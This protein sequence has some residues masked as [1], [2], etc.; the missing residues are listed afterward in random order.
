MT[1]PPGLDELRAATTRSGI[2]SLLG[3]PWSTL[4][5]MLFRQGPGSY[6]RSWT[7]KKKSGGVRKITAPTPHLYR[8]QKNLHA[9]LTSAHSARPANHGF[10]QNRSIIT[11]ASHHTG[12]RFVLTVDLKD[13]FPSIHFGRVRGLFL[14]PPFECSA[15]AATLLAQIACVDDVLPT[16]APTSPI[17][18][19]MICSRLDKELQLLARKH[20]C[21]YTRYADD[22][23][24]ST[25]RTSFPRALAYKAGPRTT[26]AGPDLVKIIE[27]NGFKHNPD[28]TRLRSHHDRQRVT[29]LTVNQKL[30]V[31]R[32]FIRRVRGMLH[33]WD[34]FGLDQAQEY[35]SACYTKDRYPGSTPRFVDVLRGRIAY[36]ISVRGIADPLTRRIA[37]QFENLQSG[38][39]MNESISYEY[40]PAMPVQHSR[41]QVGRQLLTVMF[42]DIVGSTSIAAELGDIKWKRLLDRH[43]QTTRIN[44]ARYRGRYVK[45]TGDGVLATFYSP[46]DALRA[47][48]EIVRGV[49]PLGLEVRIGLHMGEV[50]VGSED[51]GGMAVNIAARVADLAESSAVLV[52]Q[53]IRDVLAGSGMVFDARG[54]SELK[55]VPGVW[56]LYSAAQFASS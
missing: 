27:S 40:E 15:A 10:I 38:R 32:K 41:F 42:S 13:F 30:N 7:I 25:D 19:N 54:E 17:I 43:N 33:A 26:K 4:A 9:I 18:S 6:Y 51:I 31:N 56:G 3:I 16:G 44:V 50:D 53:T 36:L 39:P 23:T 37:Q 55:G 20:G 11:N 22:L 21:W 1:A 46:S 29:G 47:A 2:S 8:I 12:R 28:K 49:K 35:M 52:S 5:W 34:K 45:S 48:H 14:A 24:F